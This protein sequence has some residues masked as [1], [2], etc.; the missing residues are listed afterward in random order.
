MHEAAQNPVKFPP[1]Y[2]LDELISTFCVYGDYVFRFDLCVLIADPDSA[3]W[4][5]NEIRQEQQEYILLHL[6]VIIASRLPVTIF[7]GLTVSQRQ[8]HMTVQL[9]EKRTTPEMHYGTLVEPSRC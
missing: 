7:S 3:H 1:C 6:A 4:N 2:W 8:Y 9:S 5:K